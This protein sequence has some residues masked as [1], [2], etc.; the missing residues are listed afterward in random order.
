[1]E[2]NGG[3]L[4]FD[5]LIRDSNLQSMLDKDEQRIREFT[6]TVEGA[7]QS[8]EST[9]GNIGKIVGGVAIGAM[10]KSW[11]TDIVNTRGE[12]QQLEI[13][14]NTMLGSV[15]R[16]TQLMHE[17]TQTAAST[18][19]DLTGI[20]NS[21]K[22]LLA[23]G[24][25][26]ED[27]N[28]TLVMLGNIASGLSLP[29]NDLVYLYGTTMVQGRLFTQDVRQFMGRGIPLV[30]ELSKQLG[31]TTEEI[32]AMVTAGQ[33]GFPEVQ[34]VLQGLTA[35]GGMFYGLMEEQSKSLTGQLSNLGDA[36]D[37]MLNEIGQNTQ[38]IFSGA[39]NLAAKLVENYKSVL[40]V[41]G[42]LITIYGTYKVAQAAIAVQQGKLTGMQKIDNI[43]LSARA[44][45]FKANTGYAQAYA[46]QHG[47]MTQAQQ[48]YNLQLER[49]L[50]LEQQEQVL[51]SV[52]L[53]AIQALL[54]AEQQQFL[55]QTN[56]NTQSAEY[57]AMCESVLTADQ[58]MQLAK[59]NLTKT[60][61]AYGAALEKVVAA[62]QAESAATAQELALQ[63]RA[64]KQKEAALL[65]EYRL[66]QN[67][68]QQ[69]RVQIAL[70]QAEG[71]AEAVAALKQQQHNQLKQH[72]ILVSDLKATRTQKEALTQQIA[73][74][75][76]NQAALAGT[77]KAASDAL[78]T[79]STTI[80]SNAT[81]FLT[82]K[83]KALWATLIAN[84]FTA[85]LSLVGLVASAFMMF[86]RKQEEATTIA[87]EFNESVSES[88]ARLN[89]YF[90]IL[91]TAEK[92]TKEFKDT[93]QK[94]NTMCNEYNLTQLDTN[95]TLDEQIQKHDEL[96]EAV[97]R[98]SA[99]K[100]AAKYKEEE[101]TKAI[102]EQKKA[103]EKLQE[104][105]ESATHKEIQQVM[106]DAGDGVFIQTY[107]AVNVASERIQE[108]SKALWAS[109]QAMAIEGSQQ[110]QGLT[111]DAY[112]TAYEELMG[113]IMERVQEVTQAS[114][115]EMETFRDNIE[116]MVQ[117]TIDSQNDYLANT[118]QIDAEVRAILGKPI[119][120]N[121]ARDDLD[122]T[123]LSL[124]E[125]RAKLAELE[126][127][128][129][130][131][132]FVAYGYDSLMGMIAAVKAEI[133][134]KQNNLNTENGINSEIKTL[135]DLRGEAEIGSAKWKEYDSQIKKLQG[136]LPKTASASHKAHS[137][138]NKAARA[139]EKRAEAEKD[140][141][142]KTL[143]AEL[144]AE[145]M[146]I[147]AIKD[148]YERRRQELANQHKKELARID[149]EQAELEKK[150]KQA[151]KSMP[152]NA[153][154]AFAA[155]RT[156][157]NA[158]YEIAQTELIETEINERK[159]QYEQYYKWVTLYGEKAA[160]EQY[161][162][163]MKL[164][165]TYQQW[166]ESR[167]AELKKLQD[168]GT[169]TEADGNALIQF[170][171][172][173]N[174]IKGVKSAIDM[175]N[176]SLEKAKNNSKTTGDYLAQLAQ[177]RDNLQQGKTNL[178]GEERVKA[179]KQIEQEI[180]NTTEELERE[181]LETYKTNAQARLDVERQYDQ[182]ITW[183]RQHGYEA[184]AQQAEKAKNKAI[185]ELKATQIQG[186][187]EWQTLFQ[188]AQY[189]S[190]SAF[191]AILEELRKMVDGI[192]DSNVRAALNEQLNGLQAQVVGN[193]NPFKLLVDSIKQYEKAADGT[194]EKKQQFAQMFNAIAGSIDFVK[195]SFDS[196]VGSLTELGLA[197]DE[198]T[199]EIL[200]NISE[201][202]GASAQLA[203]GIASGN[204]LD[205][206]QGGISLITAAINLFDS[207]S[208]R[209]R[210][211]MKQ[212][213]KQ[214]KV[215]QRAYAQI[216]WETENAVGEGY[217]ASA[218]KEIENLKQQQ[219]EYEELARLENSKKKKDRDEDKY[220]D[221]LQNAEDAARQIA[222]L[223]KEMRESMVQTN[224]K[225]LANELA[226]TWADAFSNMEDAAESFDEI[227]NT[228]IANAIKNSLK[229][230]VIEPV[231]ND[232]TNALAD[233]MGAHNNSVAGFD[234]AKWKKMLQNAGE[235]F[236]NGLEGFE[237]FFQN[238]D[239]ELD[240][241]SDTLEGQIKGVT[242][243]TASMLA[244]EIIGIRIRQ[245]DMLLVQ[246]DIRSCME[247]V[248]N[249]IRNCLSY[250]N[251]ISQNTG[252]SSRYLGEIKQQLNDIKTAIASDPLR[253]KGLTS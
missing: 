132:D 213:E 152:Q 23:Y 8:V 87:G 122:L 161:S 72:A 5:V 129:V 177:M 232:F 168:A 174:A 225:D 24:T 93:L 171:D 79:T 222:D 109:V 53:A 66:S 203:K 141:A 12:F 186:T 74:A 125:L 97:E 115:D 184:Q 27:V 230:K 46:A 214:L 242:E 157:A 134:T 251:S 205:I 127:A 56:L 63:A 197:G 220:Q 188:N 244:G 245:V 22:Q 170:T 144:E 148:G 118:A 76:T 90:G 176:E 223:E 160:K 249:T 20:A 199:Q 158:N 253:A 200:G 33:I 34:K 252:S 173:L 43:V 218:A 162:D 47:A 250:L 155:Q 10:L 106:K 124:D 55:S 128:N 136:R 238:L 37:M 121:A 228:T 108:A 82:G 54:T 31:K 151:G 154:D 61:M 75:A 77:K 58:R 135:K 137:A 42:G 229:L 123:K 60:S 175:F 209:I 193:K 202:M 62:Q 48:A 59:Q 85:I 50:T 70:A 51:R 224:F 179:L 17:L 159:K 221:Y 166:I 94:V 71:N 64:L 111:G 88:Y 45:L 178:I 233:Y 116:A 67:K 30:Q 150:Y 120:D 247:S 187:A 110:L 140:A 212:H 126:G 217:Y 18:P 146:R 36:W 119:T 207:T 234:F 1:M 102:E 231:I 73:N 100:I 16:G 243:E 226:D 98:T 190:S 101:M 84:P 107:D 164:G 57:L 180:T 7:G 195:E 142:Q 139:A 169:L 149:K 96:I 113:K 181:L 167:I 133:A 163:L 145:D 86:G 216:S 215:L 21:A 89:L 65:A 19:F 165:E 52:R 3:A 206:I 41:L 172:Q 9:W 44:G 103:L 201:M 210:K 191:D 91:K 15:E 183:L 81:T 25:A 227:W 49:A 198:M 114:S 69:T 13:A 237:E 99:A 153:L 40:G 147:A 95:A 156:Y 4:S 241:A 130:T 11:V 185:A 39:I 239:D 38:G 192:Q 112:N 138:A 29:L 204:P 189:L 14:F 68:I 219:K 32:N 248:D 236:T 78:Q 6:E 2:N 194:I 26:A 131:V 196:V 117:S 143:E 105:A 211:E 35:E 104:A 246:Q 208:R 28:D 92:G 182:E 83:L 240:D 235:A 80:L